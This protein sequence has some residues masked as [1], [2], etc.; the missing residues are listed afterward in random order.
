MLSRDIF[1][2]MHLLFTQVHFPFDS[3]AGS[4]VSMLHY[5]SESLPYD[6]ED[7]M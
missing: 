7:I 6:E 1:D 5:L 3:S 4:E 2:R